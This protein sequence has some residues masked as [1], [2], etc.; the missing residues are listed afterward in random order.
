[1]KEYEVKQAIQNGQRITVYVSK[2]NPSDQLIVW[3][4][5]TC[6]QLF[7]EYLK[8]PG[9]DGPGLWVW[10]GDWKIQQ[11]TEPM[12]QAWAEHCFHTAMQV[13]DDGYTPPQQEIPDLLGA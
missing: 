8:K 11:G 12:R 9:N 4:R 7:D 3:R 6:K 2:S 13:W 10:L 1:M 5:S